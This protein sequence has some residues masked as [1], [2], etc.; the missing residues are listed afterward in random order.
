MS[1]N[2]RLIVAVDHGNYYVKGEF[3]KY[4][5]GF[6]VS[7]TKPIT[8]EGALKYKEQ[9]YGVG[10]KRTFVQTDKTEND[11]FFI[12]TLPIIAEKMD[13][14][15][16]SEANI[17]LATGLSLLNYGEQYK[18]FREYFLRDNI[19][20]TYNNK[21]YNINIVQVEVYPQGLAGILTYFKQYKDV[22][23]LALIDIGGFTTDQVFLACG[24]PIRNRCFAISTGCIHLITEIKERLES[25]GKFLEDF[26]IENIIK[27]TS[28]LSVNDDIYIDIKEI[29]NKFVDTLLKNLRE[30]GTDLAYT[31][32]I[33]SGGGAALLKSYLIDN[34][35]INS[36]KVLDD[37]EYL[38]ARGYLKLAKQMLENNN[39]DEV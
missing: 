1:M 16:L 13:R 20:F 4:K 26:Q 18:T 25:K 37:A 6:T 11:T 36:S 12:L 38:N 33:F 21:E 29:T 19:N 14:C 22:E 17:V 3:N 23:S 10:D 28:S 15:N 5:S 8:N 32:F 34:T 39:S 2:S 35:L 7:T 24:N 9:Y 30:K 27:G 31:K